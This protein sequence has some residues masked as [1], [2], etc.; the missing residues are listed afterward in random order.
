MSDL[1]RILKLAG[2]EATVEET[3]SLAPEITQREM[4]DVPVTEEPTQEAAGEFSEPL[5][6]LQDELGLEDNILVDELARWMDAQDI[7]DFVKTFRQNHEMSDSLNDESIE[8][9]TGVCKD[10]GCEI[11]NCKPGCECTH[12]SHDASGDHWVAEAKAKPDFA[13]IDG[14]GDKDEDMKKAAKDKEDLDEAQSPAQKA[15][16]AKMLASKGG[17]KADESDETDTDDK[18]ELDESP[19]MDTTQLINLM[20]NSGLSEEAIETKLTEWANTPDGAAEEEATSHGEPYENFAQSVN[21]SLKRY[22]DAED[23]KVGLK[24]HKVDD[25]KEAY[26]NAK[27]K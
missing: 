23:M 4:K 27:S 21:L 17:K 3:P 1:D 6:A 2:R 19:T 13:D 10:C 24:E 22:L 18:E 11:D 20:K 12:D 9:A 7:T 25:I 14:D 5:Y 15:A 8:E 16:F 26:K